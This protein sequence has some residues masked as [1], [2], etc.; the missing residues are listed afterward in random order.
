MS[1]KGTFGLLA[2]C[3]L[4]AACSS[5]PKGSGDADALDGGADLAEDVQAD[6]PEAGPP[7]ADAPEAATPDASDAREDEGGAACPSWMGDRQFGTAQDDA[8]LGLAATRMGVV[9]GGYVGGSLNVSRVDPGGDARGFVRG[10][11]V[12]GETVWE[13]LV[14]ATGTETVDAIAVDESGAVAVAGRTT[15]AFPGFVNAGEQDAF[16]AWLSPGGVLGAVR[17]FGD[18]RPQHPRRVLFTPTGL[19]VGGFDDYYV[20]A[21]FVEDWENPFFATVE[22]A[23]ATGVAFHADRTPPTDLAAG[24]ALDPLGSG[25]LFLSGVVST[26]TQ[27]GLFVRRVGADGTRRWSTRLSTLGV[28]V[29][30]PLLALPDGTLW[31]AAGWLRQNSTSDAALL[32]VDAATGALIKSFDFPSPTGTEEV[33]G[34][35]RD[36][37]G[38]FWLAGNVAG[39]AFPGATSAGDADAFVLHVAADGTFIDGWQGGTSGQDLAMALTTDACGN[40]V[41]GGS[42][43][44][45]F[46]SGATPL[47]GTDAFVRRVPLEVRASE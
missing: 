10:L 13:T 21:N 25:D 5:S 26:G 19:A 1:W 11:S 32:H 45:A 6:V 18:E 27:K 33:T 2:A 37:R 43:E 14:D 4:A 42:T 22:A 7:D 39:V 41:I 16:V 30:G 9:V 40:V 34:M 29:S 23:P 8:V 17:Q 3:A 47:G 15:G 46:V 44:G 20:P 28:E 31:F 24:L 35:V 36:A 12:T 38:D